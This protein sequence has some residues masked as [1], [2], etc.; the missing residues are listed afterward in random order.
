MAELDDF[1]VVLDVLGDELDPV[2][3]GYTAEEPEPEEP[4]DGDDEDEFEGGAPVEE[5]ALAVAWN[6][7]N[8]LFAVGLIAKTMPSS[9]WPVWRQYHQVGVVSLMVIWNEGT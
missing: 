5:E 8:V 1:G 2:P 4:D 9:Q 6:A 3:E 7:W